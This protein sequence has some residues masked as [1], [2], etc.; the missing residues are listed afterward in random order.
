MREAIGR[1]ETRMAAHDLVLSPAKRKLLAARNAFTRR[2]RHAQR[3]VGLS[4][5]RQAH[6]VPGG[7]KR[8]AQT[9][10]RDLHHER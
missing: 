5:L 6:E 9:L 8:Q 10:Q 1:P 4:R 3:F 2:L 7:L